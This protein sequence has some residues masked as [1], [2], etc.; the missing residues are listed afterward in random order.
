MCICEQE[1]IRYENAS[2]TPLPRGLYLCYLK[3]KSSVDLI[4]IM[5]P[6]NKPN[7]LPFVQVRN[8]PC[9]TRSVAARALLI[10]LTQLGV[11]ELILCELIPCELILCGT[12]RHNLFVNYCFFLLK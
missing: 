7:I 11:I 10:D 1:M 3:L 8:S 9:V 6:Q 5:V 4:R 2:G 12:S